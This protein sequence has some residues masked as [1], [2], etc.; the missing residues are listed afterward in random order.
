MVTTTPQRLSALPDNPQ[1]GQW[2][3]ASQDFGSQL[4]ATVTVPYASTQHGVQELVAAPA[5]V[6]DTI[7]TPLTVEVGYADGEA[8]PFKLSAADIARIRALPG[9]ARSTP[10]RPRTT[11]ITTFAPNQK[12]DFQVR[13][14]DGVILATMFIGHRGSRLWFAFQE[15]LGGA[16]TVKFYT[17]L[18][19]TAGRTYI[20]TDGKWEDL[21]HWIGALRTDAEKAAITA[22]VIPSAL[23]V[24]SAD[25]FPT[26]KLIRSMTQAEFTAE[27]DQ[28]G[29]IAIPVTSG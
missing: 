6:V 21:I 14:F 15:D 20:Y 23:Q 5:Q 9:H 19:A 24:N 1:T 10:G 17:G 28:T 13:T 29:L 25:R 18:N 16:A 22:S 11:P 2:F 4:G 8:V 27:A 26:G 7:T 3:V 12:L